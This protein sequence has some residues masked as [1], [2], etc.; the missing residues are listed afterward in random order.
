MTVGNRRRQGLEYFA[1]VLEPPGRGSRSS[2]RS[3]DWQWRFEPRTTHLPI[4]GDK[5]SVVV[6]DDDPQRMLFRKIMQRF[7]EP[8]KVHVEC[9]GSCKATIHGKF[10]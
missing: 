3:P 10:L 8:D 6:L 5:Y 4:H 2:Y 7:D 1:W 9:E